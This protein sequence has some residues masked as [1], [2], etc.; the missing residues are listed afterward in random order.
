L[1]FSLPPLQRRRGGIE[2]ALPLFPRGRCGSARYLNLFNL[3]VSVHALL[4]S[5]LAKR[6]WRHT[7]MQVS[8]MGGR[9]PGKGEERNYGM[10]WAT[11]HI[12]YISHHSTS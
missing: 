2:R 7:G 3:N 12:N 4:F 8:K 10:V 9:I 5:Q 11:Y 1:K 6:P